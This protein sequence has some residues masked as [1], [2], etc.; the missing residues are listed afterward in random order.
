MAKLWDKGY[1]VDQEVEAFTTGDDYL[2][3]RELVEADCAASIAHARMLAKIGVLMADEADKLA[4]ELAA[5]AADSRS[6][7]FTVEPADE[8]CHT[9][10]ENRL[11][12]RLGDLG[13]KVHT[14]RSRNDQ[15]IV[16]LRLYAK[17]KMH[18]LFDAG[19]GL[20]RPTTS[21]PSAP[22]QAMA[23]RCPLTASSRATCL[24]S[25]VSRTTC[26][27]PTTAAARSS[28]SSSAPAPRSPLT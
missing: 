19:L 14:C 16:A 2:L 10:I 1:A 9:A 24:G 3:D 22:P 25:Q 6:G 26:F 4:A 5:I 18:E 12:A 21:A 28:R 8:D 17:A 15:V 13:K 23:C 27:T 7:A 11:V 20:A